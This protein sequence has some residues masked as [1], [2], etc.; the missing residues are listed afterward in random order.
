MGAV[1]MLVGFI[2]CGIVVHGRLHRFGG[3]LK[4]R[5]LTATL[6]LPQMGMGNRAYNILASRSAITSALVAWAKCVR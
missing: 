2:D 5:V 1:A 4:A 6:G 3:W